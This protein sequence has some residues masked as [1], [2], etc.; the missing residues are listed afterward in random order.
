MRTKYFMCQKIC[1]HLWC[2]YQWP[3]IPIWCTYWWPKDLLHCFG[4]I[5]RFSPKSESQPI[6]T[7]YGLI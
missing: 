3:A 2:Y 4:W 6:Y 7:N 5:F 1:C